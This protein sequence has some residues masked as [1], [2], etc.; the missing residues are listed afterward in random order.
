MKP[1][2]MLILLTC[3]SVYPFDKRL[4]GLWITCGFSL[5]APSL[6]TLDTNAIE[7][8]PAA[9]FGG[10]RI[11]SSGKVEEWNLARSDSCTIHSSCQLPKMT[12]STMP[13]TPCIR[14]ALKIHYRIH[15][16]SLVLSGWGE[17]G[18]TV[19]IYRRTNREFPWS[20]WPR[21]ICEF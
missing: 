19:Q 5:R 4:V 15:G 6:V 8:F 10:L 13:W 11:S 16:D 20:N 7:H 18:E 12:D 3:T 2:A 21:T 9:A 1:L 17:Y 14:L